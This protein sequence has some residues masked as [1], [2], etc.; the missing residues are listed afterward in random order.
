MIPKFEEDHGRSSVF[1]DEKSAKEHF[2][3]GLF[4]KELEEA[5]FD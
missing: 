2:V 3:R 5:G 4:S 1:S